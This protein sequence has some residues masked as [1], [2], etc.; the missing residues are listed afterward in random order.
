MT[1]QTKPE[2]DELTWDKAMKEELSCQDILKGHSKFP[3]QDSVVNGY[4]IPE[5]EAKRLHKLDESLKDLRRGASI[6]YEIG[7]KDGERDGFE[8]RKLR[9][10][11][12]KFEA[13]VL[14]FKNRLDAEHNLIPDERSIESPIQVMMIF[15]IIFREAIEEI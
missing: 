10:R 6:A 5:S 12:K 11:L 9:E 13:A 15:D 1:K 8:V 4:F 14:A 2:V 3:F 7:Y